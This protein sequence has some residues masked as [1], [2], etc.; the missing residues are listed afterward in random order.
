METNGAI[1]AASGVSPRP[2]NDFDRE[3]RGGEIGR[4]K[5][6]KICWRDLNVIFWSYKRFYKLQKKGSL[7]P[8][9]GCSKGKRYQPDYARGP[10]QS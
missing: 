6:F 10:I 4:S 8:L 5:G 7:Q 2:P 9:V 1:V 3:V